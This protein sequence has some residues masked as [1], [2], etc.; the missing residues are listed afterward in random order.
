MKNERPRPEAGGA[1]EGPWYDH[2]TA[3]SEPYQ[4]QP[5]ETQPEAAELAALIAI[6]N[7]LVNALERQADRPRIEPMALRIEEVAIAV[8]VSR[9][10]IERERAAGRFPQP[11]LTIG[12][13]PLWRP[14]TILSFLER[15]NRQ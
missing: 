13:M 3:P 1:V 6:L 11:D 15:G 10:G 14:Q 4:D 9:R 7:R 5:A 2:P 8:G 12:K